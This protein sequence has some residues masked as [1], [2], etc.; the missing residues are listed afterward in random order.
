M[1]VKYSGDPSVCLI[2]MEGSTCDNSTKAWSHASLGSLPPELLDLILAHLDIRDIKTLR[3]SVC[4]HEQSYLRVL[5][6]SAYISILD[7]DVKNLVE[8]ARHPALAENVRDIY[9]VM[10]PASIHE[11]SD[12][13]RTS[14]SPPLFYQRSYEVATELAKAT[15]LSPV[16]QKHGQSRAPP[17]RSLA[18][19]MREFQPT[20]I[21]CILAMRNVQCIY[22]IPPPSGQRPMGTAE[23]WRRRPEDKS[24]RSYWG[25]TSP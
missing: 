23:R 16:S 10:Y 12:W 22:I 6:S 4:S 2:A 15:M 9:W 18:D 14:F 1:S 17:F 19:A 11:L 8:I 24:A 21:S 20:L 7:R 25:R 3:L 13:L 5:Y